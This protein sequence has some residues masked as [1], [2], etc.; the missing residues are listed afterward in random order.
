MLGV[1]YGERR[2]GLALSDPTGTLATPL[3]TLTYRK[4]KRPPLTE[5][6]QIAR[7]SSVERIVI[8]LPLDLAGEETGR[9][10]S[11]RRLS[12][13]REGGRRS[14]R[15]SLWQLPETAARVPHCVRDTRLQRRQAHPKP[16]E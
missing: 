16:A 11:F 4:G 10:E 5:V 1:D 3:K 8:G 13:L 15:P 2:I 14:C 9:C 12:D 7:D 6:E